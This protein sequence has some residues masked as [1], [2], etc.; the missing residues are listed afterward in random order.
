MI[1]HNAHFSNKQIG[2]RKTSIRKLCSFLVIYLLLIVSGEGPLDITVAKV[3]NPVRDE[4]AICRTME[5]FPLLNQH[6]HGSTIVEQSNG[7]LLAAWFQGSGERWADDVAI[8]G[9]RLKVGKE[10]WS[11]TFLM[12]DVP[13]FPDINPILF[14]DTQN[15]LWLMWYTV[16]ANQWETSLPKYR[17]SENYMTQEGP[18]EW[19]WQDVLYVKPG[20]PAERGIQPGDRFVKSVERQI[21][22]YTDYISQSNGSLNLITSSLA[23]RWK[24]ELL[25]KARGEDMM[26]RGRLVDSSGQSTEQ[27]LGYPYFRRMGWQTKNK[28]VIIDKNRIIVPLYSDGF[29]F[30]LM[31]ITDDGGLTWQFSEPLVAPGNIQPSIAKKAD[32]TLV[33]YMRDNGPPPKRLHVSTSTDKGLTWSPVRDSKLPNPGSG[34]DVVTMR[35][36]HW[37]LAYNDTEDGRHSLAISISTDEG[38]S[39]EYT[40]HL[41]LDIRERNIATRSAYPSIIQG[42]GDM[43]HVV[44]SY[45]HND[46]KGAPNKTIKYATFNEAWVMQGDALNSK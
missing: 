14:I 38:K 27:Q 10:T 35:N 2:F 40:R 8:M 31:A 32:G 16:I 21:K 41:E 44:Y 5:I 23:D 29:S 25:T 4:E 19:T 24:A 39:W 11:K 33:A 45:H 20:D 18:P 9:A 22:E 46:R 17:I 13:K 15:R 34:A 6:V 37:V 28:A 43:L 3:H 30:S 12:A 7:D 36:G 26:R 1:R 42:R